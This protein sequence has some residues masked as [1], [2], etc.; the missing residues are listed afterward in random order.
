[1][2]YVSNRLCPE[3]FAD[4]IEP[5]IHFRERSLGCFVVAARV[6]SGAYVCVRA[7]E[8]VCVV[9]GGVMPRFSSLLFFFLS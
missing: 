8:C 7:R 6:R 3:N 9:Y 4:D 5:K 2:S 1:V